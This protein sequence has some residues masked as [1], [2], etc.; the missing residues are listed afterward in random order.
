VLRAIFATPFASLPLTSGTRLN[1]PLA[2]LL[3]ARAQPERREPSSLENPLAFRSR[4]D[5][6]G[7]PDEP[8]RQLQAEMLGA[9]AAIVNAAS[10]YPEEHIARL[11][12]QARARFVLIR[13]D[14]CLSGSAAYNCS[15]CMVYCVAAPRPP[16]SR[17]DSGAVRLYDLRMRT[18][19]VD[20][21]NAMLRPEFNV[22][23]HIW[24]PTPGYM[25]A[26]PSGVGYEVALNRTPD[27]ILLVIARVRL[28]AAGQESVLPW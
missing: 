21:G 11:R 15:W 13:P 28:E 14:G 10:L 26:F 5:L 23:H 3:R 7:W 27:D 18:G 12:M 22:N 2:A 24:Q 9:L 17:W 8:I 20:A 25:T 16:D 19:F 1:S 6:F 4:E